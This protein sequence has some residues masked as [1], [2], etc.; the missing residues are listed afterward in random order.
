MLRISKMTDYG[1][2]IMRFLANQP[3]EKFTAKEIASQTKLAEPTVSKLLKTLSKNK[4]LLSHRG[5]N[6]GYSI[7]RTASEISIADIIGA[8]EG[9]IA[10]TECGLQSETCA[11]EACCAN[12]N[13]W[14]KVNAVVKQTLQGISLQEFM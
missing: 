6:G 7:V 2:V 8:I 13:P 5:V 14:M 12:R 11:L 4:L 10:L 1:T 9:D 3:A